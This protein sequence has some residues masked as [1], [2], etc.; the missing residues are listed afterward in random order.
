MQDLRVLCLGWIGLVGPFECC[1]CVFRGK[2]R[3]KRAAPS[4]GLQVGYRSP[5]RDP[6]GERFG[7][8]HSKQCQGER[9]DGHMGLDVALDWPVTTLPTANHQRAPQAMTEG[10]WADGHLLVHVH[11]NYGLAQVRACVLALG[12]SVY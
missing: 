4:R 2:Q 12:A 3:G 10:G 5:I 11:H 7:Y 6:S 9:W 8:S 1:V